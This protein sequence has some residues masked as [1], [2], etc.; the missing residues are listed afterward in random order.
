MSM[1]YWD[2]FYEQPKSNYFS[3]LVDIKCVGNKRCKEAED[4]WSNYLVA[5][6]KC[7]FLAKI[8]KRK[9]YLHPPDIKSVIVLEIKPSEFTW[10]D[11]I[12]DY[13]IRERYS[14]INASCKHDSIFNFFVSRF[15]WSVCSLFDVEY[16][17]NKE[18]LRDFNDWLDKYRVIIDDIF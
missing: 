17:H 3:Q 11:W 4:F 9:S 18:I 2:N 16:A 13:H 8:D 1:N 10:A 6:L 7:P 14:P 12:E 15:N 5:E